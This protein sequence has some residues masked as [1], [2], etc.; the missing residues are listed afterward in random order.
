[1]LPNRFQPD[2]RCVAVLQTGKRCGRPVKIFSMIYCAIHHG[3]EALRRSTYKQDDACGTLES[4]PNYVNMICSEVDLHSLSIPEIERLLDDYIKR[5]KRVSEC[6]QRRK[7]F[8]NS[9]RHPE[10]QDQAHVND[11]SR[12][13]GMQVDCAGLVEQLTARLKSEW[14]KNLDLSEEFRAKEKRLIEEA[15]SARRQAESA[16]RILSE[17]R[18]VGA[19]IEEI[20]NPLPASQFRN[21]PSK[22][23]GNK[24]SRK[25]RKGKEPA[26]KPESEWTPE[27]RSAVQAAILL[28]QQ[29]SVQWNALLT[30]QLRHMHHEL[31]LPRPTFTDVWTYLFDSSFSTDQ[32]TAFAVQLE[33]TNKETMNELLRFR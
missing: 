7:S 23:S 2:G 28:A 26:S 22:R 17:V 4:N 13:Q 18:R 8:R 15:E 25:S 31:G 1:M 3:C 16:E 32:I 29:E 30:L 24:K 10:T 5:Q 6:I 27:D 19:K 14:D 33:N 9:C 12:V 11:D 21:P 20:N